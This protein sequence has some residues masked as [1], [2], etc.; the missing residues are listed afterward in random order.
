[1]RK[2][3][4]ALAML[5]VSS[6]ALAQRLPATVTPTHYA[7]WFA[8][9]LQNATFRGRET[10]DVDVPSATTT[11]TLNAAEIQFGTVTMTAGGRMQT[12]RV[13]L[14]KKNEMGTLT[15]PR[16]LPKGPAS[17]QR[18]YSGIRNDT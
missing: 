5:A 3:V 4:F 1:M 2:F 10:I 14:D 15:V 13:T 7:L 17:I 9:D 8:P 18:T 12:A 6:G 16:P 11:I